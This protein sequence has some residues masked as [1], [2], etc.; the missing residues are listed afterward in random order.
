[1]SKSYWRRASLRCNRGFYPWT[2]S[3]EAGSMAGIPLCCQ[4]RP[5]P[6]TRRVHGVPF[7]VLAPQIETTSF[8]SV[9]RSV[10]VPFGP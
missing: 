10:A 3:F 2:M 8:G 7:L 5:V 9:G 1:M 6:L 4:H